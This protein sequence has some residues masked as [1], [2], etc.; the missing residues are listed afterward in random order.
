MKIF[1]AEQVKK[2]DQFTIENEP[3]SSTELM[4]RAAGKL[5]KKL[6][7]FIPKSEQITVV[8][9]V[10]N[11]GGDGLVLTRLLLSQGYN[12]SAWVIRFSDQESEDFSINYHRLQEKNASVIK[13]IRSAS[14]IPNLED[15]QVIVDAL[16]GSGL[17]REVE[18]FPGKVID[19][20]NR[21]KSFKVAVDVPSGLYCED[22]TDNNG[23]IFKANLT[24]TFQYPK[25]AFFFAENAPFVGDFEVLNIGLHPV[26][27]RQEP[28]KYHYTSTALVSAVHRTRSKFTHKGTYGHSLIVAGSRGKI[29]A[30]ILSAQ[31]CL[32]SGT[33]LL[34]LGIPSAGYTAM[35][36]SVPEAMCIELGE[37]EITENPELKPFNSIGV[38]PGI[39]TNEETAQ[40]L[41]MLIQNSG[42]PMVIDADGLNLLA[43]NQTWLNF[44]PASSILTPHPGE[45]ARF[46]GKMDRSWDRLEAAKE[47][48]M[49]NR[50]YVV[51]KGANTQIAC[52]DG[53]VF[54]NSTGNPGMATGGSGD[55][56]TGII[57]ALLAQRY[58]AK[59][60]A[61]LGVFIHGRAGD[62]AL[63]DTAMES[64]T[65]QDI[66]AYLPEA[67]KSIYPKKI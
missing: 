30:A 40:V 44:L 12:T 48:A 16:F 23:S 45:L 2:A 51:L 66:I 5:F 6:V 57:T 27:E 9:G 39:G 65:A 13:E 55:V 35:Q 37:N 56:L 17:S 33:G 63:A 32:K 50:V 67:W 15:G 29:G 8:C 26:F 25:L 21:C 54:F 3:V 58:N 31:A 10:G 36:T 61:V 47:I 34:T 62:L 64:L 49:K 52:P 38:G 60:A 19:E 14:E 59:E 22:N 7:S 42:N 46:V 11:N 1:T 53:D 18:G 28:S 43:E 24:L 20:L 4:E 41:K